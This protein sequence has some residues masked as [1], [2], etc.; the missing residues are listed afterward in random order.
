MGTDA[1][2]FPISH[3][4]IS[5]RSR[6]VG[7]GT[8][9]GKTVRDS[10]RAVLI[11]GG[12]AGLFMIGTGAPYGAAPE[13]ASLELRQQFIRGLTALPLALR[14]L[15]GEPIALETLGGFLSWR[16]GNILPV[17]LGLWS[18]LALSGTLAGEA[19]KG[20]LDL[21]AA[22]PHARRTIALQKVAGHI[23]AVV[24]AMFIAGVVISIIG[25]SFARLPGDEIPATAA[26]G[27]VALYGLLMFASG[28][29][30]F[31][32]APFVGRTRALAI[33]LAALF[34][35]YLI[36]S[37][38]TLSDVIAGLKPLSWYAWTA[39]HRPMAGVSDWGS[40]G[41]LALVCAAFI[42]IGVLAFGRRD[43]GAAG[44]LS[45]LRLPSLPAGI[46][47]PFTRQLADRTAAAIAW[48]GGIGLYAALVVASAEAFS[49]S[50]ASL[51]QIAELIEAIYPGVDI[52]QPSGILQLTFFGFATVMTGLA[53]A[54]FLMAWAGDEHDGRLAM[55][56]A[57]PLTRRDWLQG[58]GLGVYG[59]IGVMT[60]VLAAIVAIA[61]LTQGGDVVTPVVGIGILGLATIGFTGLGLTAGG[62]VRASLAAPVTGA[63]VIATF[64]LDTLGAALDLPDPVLQ[65][66]LYKHLGQPMAGTY[67]LA[68]I[69][70]A[71]AFALSGLI[72]G[73]WALQRRDLDR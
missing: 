20:S 22:T 38:A 33:G 6:L 23:T 37:Y 5:L 49:E 15:L 13:F 40:V 57:A 28:S 46:H 60:L 59:A 4:P 7:L 67:D 1:R 44:A 45:W 53:G 66:S 64:L 32:A 14:G 29:V 26:F 42:A 62:L 24:L 36:A 11:V 31:A 71:L 21:L 8:I 34:A 48:G 72:V 18:V 17:M 63:V 55:V 16:V 43:I 27:Q 56:L 47:G 58:S 54:T 69:V 19:A 61:V 12:L 25:V 3:Q 10:L 68:G 41:L 2:T 35:P 50:I 30:A 9:Y 73:G 70:V 52:H 39:G 51:P 65:L